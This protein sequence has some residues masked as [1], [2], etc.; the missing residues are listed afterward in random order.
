[1]IINN[2]TEPIK[3]LV[4]FCLDILDNSYDTFYDRKFVTLNLRILSFVFTN[5]I[6]INNCECIK[7]IFFYF[8][9]VEYSYFEG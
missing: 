4:Q 7:K 3:P 5:K 1:M 2:H 9:V 8:I 6:G